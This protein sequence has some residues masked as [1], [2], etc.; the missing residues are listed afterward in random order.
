VYTSAVKRGGNMKSEAF[1]VI[2]VVFLVEEWDVPVYLS[3]PDWEAGFSGSL[4][5]SCVPWLHYSTVFPHFHSF[6]LEDCTTENVTK[7]DL[8]S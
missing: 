3:C 2:V 6:L 8:E 1:K 4:N 5:H 7:S